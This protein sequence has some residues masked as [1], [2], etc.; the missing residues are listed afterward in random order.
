MIK[1]SIMVTPEQLARA[2][3]NRVSLK[4]DIAMDVA[5]RVMDYFGFEDTIIDNILNQEDRRLFYFLQDTGLMRTHWEETFLPSG[6]SWRIFYWRLN[7]SKIRD[8]A[9]MEEETEEAE[10]GLYESLPDNAW[11]HQ[12]AI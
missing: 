5:I 10:I 11:C 7:V 6:R 1:T 9:Q 12:G 2:L 8:Y 4:K 3:E